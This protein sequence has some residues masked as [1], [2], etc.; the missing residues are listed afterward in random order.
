MLAGKQRACLG[1][2]KGRERACARRPCLPLGKTQ[3]RQEQ[4]ATVATGQTACYRTTDYRLRVT[5]YKLQALGHS[6][7]VTGYKLQASG[8]R[9]QATGYRLLHRLQAAAQTR[10]RALHVGLGIVSAW[11][12]HIYITSQSVQSQTSCLTPHQPP[13][14]TFTLHSHTHTHTHTST[15]LSTQ[16]NSLLFHHLHSLLSILHIF[17]SPPWM[18]SRRYVCY[19]HSTLPL[20]SSNVAT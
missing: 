16:L 20:M 11:S 2:G 19:T 4:R 17:P 13:L 1:K 10:S 7:R 6:L 3:G 12:E 15:S 5:G 18:P 8:F 14:L 9:L